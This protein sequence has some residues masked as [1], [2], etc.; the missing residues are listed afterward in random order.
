MLLPII[1]SA[2]SA[3]AQHGPYAPPPHPTSQWAKSRP[4]LYVG[5]QGTLFLIAAQ[6]TDQVGYMGQG[7]GGGLFLGYRVGPS[8]GIELNLNGTYHSERLGGGFVALDALFL[9]TAT[10]DVKV[11]FPS[12]GQVEPFL[13]A[14]A[15]YGY[16]GATYGECGGFV[17]DT[18][19]AQGPAFQVGGGFD[20]WLTPHVTF[21]ARLLYRAIYFREAAY[22]DVVVRQNNANFIN[23]F[24]VDIGAAFHF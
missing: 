6:V 7:G 23:G 8:V 12:R 3:S 22:G 15:G 10:V 5:G 9:M 14:G 19:F 18:T 11:H 24:V 20:Y 16:L 4:H 2:G 1:A 17:C 13:Q 21:G